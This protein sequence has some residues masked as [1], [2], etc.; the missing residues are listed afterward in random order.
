M[1]ICKQLSL[2]LHQVF[3][4]GNWTWS[5]LKDQLEGVTWQQATAKTNDLNTILA[6]TYHIHYYVETL[7]K[8]LDGKP[9]DSK[10][11]YSFDH[12]VMSNESDW[13]K[14]K[15]KVF[16]DVN[17]LTALIAEI[18]DTELGSTFVDPKYGHYHRN[19]MGLIEH[20]H[21]HLGQI[22]IIKKLVVTI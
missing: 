4:G 18:P 22:A 13:E 17:R 6:L 3:F 21:Y 5:N 8:V 10:D 15:A 19:L 16:D 14:F 11:K 7:L 2:H 12:P 1:N 9:L 20:T